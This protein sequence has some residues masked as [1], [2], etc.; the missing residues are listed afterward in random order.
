M[1]TEQIPVVAVVGPTASGKSRLAVE[2]AKWLN[3]EVVSADSMQ[4]YQEMTIGTAK[5]T[6]EEMEG[7]PHHMI[8]FLPVTSPFN[9]ADYVSMAKTCLQEIHNR[10]KIPVLAGGTGLYVRSLLQNLDFSEGDHDLSLREELT[11]LANREGVE[12]LMEELRRIDPESAERIEPNNLPRVIRAIEL[13]RTTGK[14]MTQHLAAS[15]RNPSPYQVCMIGL[16]YQDRSVLYDRIN[17]RVDEMMA[18][19]LLEEARTLLQGEG[20]KTALQAIGYKELK[21][22]FDGERSLEES[23]AFMKQATRRYAKRQLTW[24]RR[25]EKIHWLYPDAYE[26][27]RLLLEDAKE[28]VTGTFGGA[29][30]NDE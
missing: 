8:D 28:L 5:I 12:P 1:T 16:N 11:E 20:G 6:P 23:V 9:V 30:K 29:E 2:L 21:P 3:S 25:E 4:I 10:G 15:R 13:Y 18:Q 24:F 7:V 14:T 19:G 17:R 26:D 27:F 22:Y